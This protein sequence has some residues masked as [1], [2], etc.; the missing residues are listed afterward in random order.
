MTQISNGARSRGENPAAVLSVLG[1]LPEEELLAK[2]RG[3]NDRAFG[4][5][6]KRNARASLRS[7]VYLAGDLDPEDLL[8][9]SY[10]RVFRILKSGRGPA[11]G[12]RT[13]VQ[14]TM[15]NVAASIHR[16]RSDY[17]NLD[18]LWEGTPELTDPGFEERV[19]DSSLVRQALAQLPK[20]WQ[21]VLWCTEVL[22][23]KPREL[24]SR[25]QLT[26]NS[27]AALA[28]R[29]RAGLKSK[30]LE[31]H[32][33]YT[34]R[35]AECQAVI[36]AFPALLED[37]TTPATKL[38]AEAHLDWCS[39]CQ[40]AY[41]ET[42]RVGSRSLK[43]TALSVLLL[44]AGM[45]P[46]LGGEGTPSAAAV[47]TNAG[48]RGIAVARRGRA[49][50]LVAAAAVAGLAAYFAFVAPEGARSAAEDPRPPRSAPHAAAEPG[51]TERNP[52]TVLAGGF[53]RVG[54]DEVMIDGG[55]V[56]SVV[57]DL[58]GVSGADYADALATIDVAV[59]PADGAEVSALV[60]NPNEPGLFT[61]GV[62]SSTPDTL[63]VEVRWR[64]WLILTEDGSVSAVATFG[65]R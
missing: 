35:P 2:V 37:S 20:E 36:R 16:S 32:V 39:S 31:L 12:F 13:Y 54:A 46:L 63:R 59:T 53:F 6:W 18:D 8:A 40:S 5:L 34:S 14:V 51:A 11:T 23:M 55:Y 4:E 58:R 65:P 47:T 7:A 21:E 45:L 33:A 1:T 26:P 9:E 3:G 29:A 28:Y 48:A 56:R 44:S 52:G 38:S 62:L 60:E 25:L 30:W 10:L 43:L 61:A 22:G 64:D 24:A 19:T 49:V 50:L 15:K 41:A 27:A 17:V 57:I 42:Q